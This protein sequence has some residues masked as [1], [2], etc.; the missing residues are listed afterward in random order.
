MPSDLLA[1]G[2]LSASSVLLGLLLPLGAGLAIV[3]VG[4]GFVLETWATFVAG[5]LVTVGLVAAGVFLRVWGGT[6]VTAEALGAAERTASLVFVA[7]TPVG[8]ILGVLF[9]VAGLVRLAVDRRAASSRS[10][11]E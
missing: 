1:T 9:V 11:S 5:L 4:R 3:G 10:R 8:V 7:V 6:L 2:V